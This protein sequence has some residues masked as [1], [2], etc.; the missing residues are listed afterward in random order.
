MNSNLSYALTKVQFGQII[1]SKFKKNVDSLIE[2]LSTDYPIF[3]NGEINSIKVEFNSDTNEQS[4][5]RTK[6]PV[7]ILKS[8]NKKW[9]VRITQVDVILHTNAYSTYEDFEQKIS[10]ILNALEKIMNI[11]HFDFVGLRYLNKLDEE[12]FSKNFKRTEFL[13][14]NIKGLSMAGS[15][16][17]SHYIDDK[18]GININSGVT[19][20]NTKFPPDLSDLVIELEQVNPVLEGA[21]AHLDID[22]Y[23]REDELKP[24]DHSYIM[25]TLKELRKRAKNAYKSIIE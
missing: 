18:Y 5:I 4:S 8:A 12:N 15:N 1:D 10:L 25:N 9:G 3:L 24:Y 16:N 17:A 13:Q 11:R 6:L 20:N 7:I 21:W 22:V 19:I 2:E 14:P 23:K